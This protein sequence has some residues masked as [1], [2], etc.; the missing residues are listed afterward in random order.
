M[1]QTLP[2][3]MSDLNNSTSTLV[4]QVN[5]LSGTGVLSDGWGAGD[6][7]T[8][9][10][11]AANLSVQATTATVATSTTGAAGDGTLA[12]KIADLG[13]QQLGSGQTINGM[14]QQ[15]VTGVGTDAA[16]ADSV[17]QAQSLSL[18][19]FQTQ[20]QSVS[21]VSLDEEMTN[22]VQ[23]QQAYSAAA[24][25]LTTVDNMISTLFT[26]ITDGSGG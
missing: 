26:D 13:D 1:N 5:D 10:S 14:Y 16:A 22:M 19:Q 15:I 23:F 20:Q 3:Y 18:T 11:T 25:V 24:Q 17:S 7:F 21:G 12:G 4:S 8:P 9:G 6:F 2:G